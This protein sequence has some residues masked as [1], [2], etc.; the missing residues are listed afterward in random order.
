MR[1]AP[2]GPARTCRARLRGR[3]DASLFTAPPDSAADSGRWGWRGPTPHRASHPLGQ[4]RTSKIQIPGHRA[5]PS[6]MHLAADAQVTLCARR[7][8]I[9]GP[10]GLQL[11]TLLPLLPA[12]KALE[13]G[14]GPRMDFLGRWM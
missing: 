3:P 13:W 7:P 4:G 10:L 6:N 1:S 9:S 5:L 8:Q 14:V 12:W 11:Q 2:P